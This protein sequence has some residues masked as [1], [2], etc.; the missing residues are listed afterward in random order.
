MNSAL[1]EQVS[2]PEVSGR[3]RILVS[4]GLIQRPSDGRILVSKRLADAHLANSWEF[5]GGKVEFGEDPKNTVI[6]ELREELGIET[7]VGDIYAVGHHCY[8]ER[9]VVLLVYQT[10]IIDGEPQCLEVADFAWLTPGEVVNLPLPPAD[11]PV[12]D[13]LQR[14][15]L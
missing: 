14:D 1:R 10:A 7:S 3:K 15:C 11:Q 2:M 4:A 5:P 9:E 12:I 6:R 8:A 13:R